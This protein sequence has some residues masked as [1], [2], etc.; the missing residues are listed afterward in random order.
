M[1]RAW[2]LRVAAR[3]VQ[4]MR[5]T[6]M[7][8]AM[9][10]VTLVLGSGG[11]RG[12]AH[13]GVI[14]ALEADGRFAVRAVTGTSIGALVGGLYA[15]G[16]LADY[17]RWVCG[18]SRADV[19]GLLDFSF[20][21][22]GLFEG[23]RLMRRLAELLGDAR[24]EDLPIPFTAVASDL[25]RRQEVWLDRGSL[26]EAIRAS[27]AIPGLFTPVER[28]GRLLVDGGLLSPLPVVP[29]LQHDAPCAIAVSLNGPATQTAG[30]VDRPD[31]GSP[32]GATDENAGGPRDDAGSSHEGSD[33]GDGGARTQRPAQPAGAVRQWLRRA[34]RRLGISVRSEATAGGADEGDDAFDIIA[35]SVEAMQD[36]IARYQ[37]AGCRPDLLIEIPVDACGVLEFDRAEEMIALGERM[38]QQALGRLRG[39][40]RAPRAGAPT[41]GGRPDAL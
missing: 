21:R 3:V 2:G 41:C 24:I 11:A 18:L 19:W 13:I 12:L 17:E 23:E 1:S 30:A 16:K 33:R 27:I 14:R 37:L 22:R 5:G 9:T 15:A 7:D 25:E 39:A 38:A 36:R 35:K 6:N 26:F 10:A 34:G 4:G 8:E 29:M 40:V 32:G 31:H 20:T 28:D